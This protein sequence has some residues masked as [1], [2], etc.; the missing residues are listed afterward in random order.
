MSLEP[1]D[2]NPIP[3][4]AEIILDAKFEINVTVEEYLKEWGKFSLVTECDGKTYRVTIDEAAV[5]AL[6]ERVHPKPGVPHVTK[7]TDP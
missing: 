7:R 1:K 4:G 2:A 6:F 5:N 3:S